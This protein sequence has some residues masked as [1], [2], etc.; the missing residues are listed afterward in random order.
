MTDALDY[1]VR[2]ARPD[3]VH[4]VVGL[5]KLWAEEGCTT[6][7]VALKEDDKHLQ[8][9]FDGGYFFV[10]EH[11]GVVIAYAA[12]VVKVGK[13]AIFKP[14]GERFLDIHEVFVHVDHR[15]KGVGD[16]LVEALLSR[17]ESA[18]ISRSM[19]GSNNID[20]LRTYRFYERRGYRMFSIQMYK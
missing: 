7:Y 17:S 3:D 1:Q 10:D 13:D 9:W 20:W 15:E 2:P 4:A 18:G 6:G 5:S 8:S 11:E 19:V 12:G 16:R 14:E